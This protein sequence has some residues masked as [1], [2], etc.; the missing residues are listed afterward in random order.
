M[1]KGLGISALVLAIISI[2]IPVIGPWL[3]VVAA[4]LAAFSY[5]SALAF[6]IATLVINFVNVIFLSPSL[7]IHG[8][9]VSKGAEMHGAEVAFLPWIV[10]GAQAIALVVL[11]ALHVKSGTQSHEARTQAPTL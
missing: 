4:L 8:A 5:G 7:W 10:L 11:I 9:L 2:F 3:A 6:G 1:N